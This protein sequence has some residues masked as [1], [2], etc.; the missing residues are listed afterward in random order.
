MC[1]APMN[2]L[3]H[4]QDP[5]ILD[6]TH[7]HLASNMISYACG[8]TPSQGFSK[9]RCLTPVCN[10]FMCYLAIVHHYL[11]TCLI[12]NT[13][14]THANYNK[15]WLVLLSFLHN[16]TFNHKIWYITFDFLPID[17]PKTSSKV[18]KGRHMLSL[19]HKS[20]N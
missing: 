16:P 11:W 19:I 2:T 4:I 9:G 7:E 10:Y 1:F 3:H 13:I 18:F 20:I 14:Y 17:P 5:R 8:V 12:L 6:I 15:I